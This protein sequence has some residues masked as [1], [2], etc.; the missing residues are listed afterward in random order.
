M[1]FFSSH[2]DSP[3]KVLFESSFTGELCAQLLVMHVLLPVAVVT[4]ALKDRLERTFQSSIPN[5]PPRGR[6]SYSPWAA[7]SLPHNDST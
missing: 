5:T 6:L 7:T 1:G 2:I 4:A 3:V